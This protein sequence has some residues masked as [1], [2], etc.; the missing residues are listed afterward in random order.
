MNSTASAAPGRVFFRSHF[1][2]ISSPGPPN[3][4]TGL[5][6]AGVYH[7]GEDVTLKGYFLDNSELGAVIRLTRILDPA[8][9]ILS[10]E[11]CRPKSQYET[12]CRLPTSDIFNAFGEYLLGLEEVGTGLLL[13][14]DHS[15]IVLLLIP[16]PIISNVAPLE[17]TVTSQT[18]TGEAERRL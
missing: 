8:E 5:P 15:L 2:E 12:T 18:L 3:N 17:T 16:D 13:N 11:A 1:L 6:T 10:L 9:V 7:P 14:D 4:L